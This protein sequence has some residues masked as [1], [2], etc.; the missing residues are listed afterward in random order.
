MFATWGAET[1]ASTAATFT[2]NDNTAQFETVDCN[3][4]SAPNDDATYNSQNW[5]SLGFYRITS[6]TLNVQL[7]PPASGGE[8]IANAVGIVNVSV[9]L[10]SVTP[11]MQWAESGTRVCQLPSP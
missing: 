5:Q 8:V 9:P 1:G 3:Q 11:P 6:G 10:V 4:A 2:I 7:S